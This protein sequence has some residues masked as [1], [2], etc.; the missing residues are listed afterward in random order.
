M[1]ICLSIPLQGGKVQ[2]RLAGGG[3]PA[4]YAVAQKVQKK[5]LHWDRK[6]VFSSRF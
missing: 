2:N 3:D 5:Q 4:A 1:T 6:P